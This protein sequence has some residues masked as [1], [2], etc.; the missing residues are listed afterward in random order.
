M[1]KVKAVLTPADIL[2]DANA[3]V[4]IN[5]SERRKV[6]TIQGK[7]LKIISCNIRGWV[8]KNESLSNIA[9]DEKA[10]IIA[11][12]ETHCQ[13][14]KNYVVYYCTSKSQIRL[15][16]LLLSRINWD[17]FNFLFVT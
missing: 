14:N 6:K 5:V 16:K 2:C 7:E 12:Q 13:G 10:D 1:E 11:L 9:K 3:N 4:C 15:I 8:S 17:S